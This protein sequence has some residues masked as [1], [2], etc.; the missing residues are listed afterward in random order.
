MYTSVIV[1]E[2]I[3]FMDLTDG[4]LLMG[5]KLHICTQSKA[6]YTAHTITHL[7]YYYLCKVVC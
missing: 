1:C 5:C 7:P 6:R 4:C 2:T 3:I